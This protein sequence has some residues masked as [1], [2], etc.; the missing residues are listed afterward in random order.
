MNGFQRNTLGEKTSLDIPRQAGW[1]KELKRKQLK[2]GG[3]SNVSETVQKLGKKG[4]K[5][6]VRENKKK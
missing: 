3:P 4:G 5:Y 1:F 2:K 6:K